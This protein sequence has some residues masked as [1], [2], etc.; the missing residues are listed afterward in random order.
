M[1]DFQGIFFQSIR[2][3]IP[4][5]R[6]GTGIG[7]A[8]VATL[9]DPPFCP[10]PTGFNLHQRSNFLHATVLPGQTTNLYILYEVDP[11]PILSSPRTSPD[12]HSP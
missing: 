2:S 10:N 11:N 9:L 7:I 12:T 8:E 4:T 6:A 1:M 3:L 5:D